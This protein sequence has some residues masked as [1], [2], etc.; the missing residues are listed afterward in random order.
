MK[1]RILKNWTVI[2]VVYLLMGI[3]MIIHSVIEKQWLGTV[4]GS[5]FS[6]MGLFAFG[7]AGGNCYIPPAPQKTKADIQE[8]HFEEVKN[9]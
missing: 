2:R 5:Y 8:I 6:A 9:K 3:A 7:C 1:E 4:F